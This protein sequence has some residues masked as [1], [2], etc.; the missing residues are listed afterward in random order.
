MFSK[1]AKGT[2]TRTISRTSGLSIMDKSFLYFS[3][4][5][6]SATS[7]FMYK[8]ICLSKIKAEFRTILKNFERFSGTFRSLSRNFLNQDLIILLSGAEFLR[9][10]SS[11]WPSTVDNWLLKRVIS[12]LRAWRKDYIDIQILEN[13]NKQKILC[14]K[15]NLYRSCK[16]IR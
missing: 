14:R 15:S 2:F 1:T 5:T 16:F 11:I 10:A 8:S 4:V 13:L 3:K 9:L 12:S 6:V 7:K